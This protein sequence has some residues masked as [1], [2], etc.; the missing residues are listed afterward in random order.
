M[1]R[2]TI[3]DHLIHSNE[4]NEDISFLVYVP[5]DF[6]PM[7]S[8][9]F[10]I[11]Q[12]GK[13]YFQMG[14]LPRVAD[15]LLREEEIEPLIIVGIPY[16]DKYDRRDKYHPEGAKQKAYIRFLAHE[17]VPYLDE[18]FPGH[19]ARFGRALAGDSLAGTVSFMA[20]LE[21]PDLFGRVLMHSPFVDST[22]IHKA[23]QAKTLPSLYHMIG[24]EETD[25]LMT[26]GE[27]ADFLTPNRTLYSLLTDKTTDYF[28]DEFAGGHTWTYWQ[29]DM[30]PAL[31]K[32]FE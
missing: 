13:D 15:E 8:Y 23:E 11:C 21:Y 30:K 22:V 17:L 4:L 24:T 7:F 1:K 16:N 19:G 9:T 18:Q 10:L 25:V 5:A 12:D 27:R 28:Y 26:N 3:Q 29:K 6:S 31:I 32:M 14:R 2:G 20:A